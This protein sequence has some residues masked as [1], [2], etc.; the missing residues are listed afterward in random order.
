MPAIGSGVPRVAREVGDVSRSFSRRL[1]ADESVVVA[2]DHPRRQD[3]QRL[4]VGE[5]AGERLAAAGRAST[6]A[7]CASVTA[8]AITATRAA[9]DDLVAELRGLAGPGRAHARHVARVGAE[10]TGRTR[11]IASGCP[12]H[13]MA[14]VPSCA[15]P[16]PPET[17]ASTHCM[18]DAAREPL[19]E[20]ARRVGADRRVVDQDLAAPLDRRR[21]RPRRTPPPPPPWC[22]SRRAA[23]CRP[24]VAA[25]RGVA[26]SIAPF[27][28]A[29][30]ELRAAAVPDVHAVARGEQAQRHR[31]R[32]CRPRPRK[33]SAGLSIS[34]PIR[35]GHSA[36]PECVTAPQVGRADQLARISRARRRGARRAAAAMRRA[37]GRSPP[38]ST[39]QSIR[40]GGRVDADAVAVAHQRDRAAGRGLRARVADAHAARRAREA[41]V[42]QQ[43]DLLAH[44]LT[45]ERA[46]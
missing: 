17:G 14:S 20:R 22:R 36:L 31:H 46:R 35:A 30:C 41:S 15:P 23:R 40:A 45:V 34:P 29:G 24:R 42:G 2:V 13:M 18:P 37:G 21:C 1:R 39:S 4:R 16:T 12:P 10:S 32:P 27:S 28:S 44:A 38:R 8:S 3:L 9:D 19:G 25:S 7:F 11:S 6:P 5:A 43:R 26:A 33:A